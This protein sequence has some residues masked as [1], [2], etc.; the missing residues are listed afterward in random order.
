MFEKNTCPKGFYKNYLRSATFHLISSR[1]NINYI[2]HQILD[3][4]EPHKIP[5]GP[6]KTPSSVYMHLMSDVTVCYITFINCSTKMFV[7]VQLCKN[8]QGTKTFE[9]ISGVLN[10]T[11]ELRHWGSGGDNISSAVAFHLQFAHTICHAWVYTARKSWNGRLLL[12]VSLFLMFSHFDCVS[13]G[14][15]WTRR[16]LMFIFCSFWGFCFVCVFLSVEEKRGRQLA[17]IEGNDCDLR[18]KSRAKCFL[19]SLFSLFSTFCP[20]K[21]HF[22]FLTP[23][24]SFLCTAQQ[25]CEKEKKK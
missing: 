16:V 4:I 12:F 25:S 21:P 3:S 7:T 23:S 20:S 22:P 11:T 2:L 17:E 10:E 19:P 1:W 15:L 5:S 14:S 9:Q 6:G 18:T 24:L 8:L 13:C